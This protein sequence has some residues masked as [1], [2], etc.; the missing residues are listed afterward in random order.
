M[1]PAAAASAVMRHLQ[2]NPSQKN[3]LKMTKYDNRTFVARFVARKLNHWPVDHFH[4]STYWPDKWTDKHTKISINWNVDLSNKRSTRVQTYCCIWK[5]EMGGEYDGSWISVRVCLHWRKS[6]GES[7]IAS[8]WVHRESNL[9]FKSSSNKDK[10][11]NHLCVRSNSSCG[12]VMFS[13]A[14]VCP[15]RGSTRGCLPRWGV[16]LAGVSA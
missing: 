16:C 15:Q 14:S 12:K 6:E 7:N 2:K 5:M 11:K 4:L 3:N 9:M 13:Q 8:R 10:R 1:I